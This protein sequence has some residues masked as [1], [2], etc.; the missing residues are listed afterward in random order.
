MGKKNWLRKAE[1]PVIQERT[2]F[3]TLIGKIIVKDKIIFG[4][5]YLNDAGKLIPAGRVHFPGS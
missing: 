5:G 4:G 1:M 2:G 3:M